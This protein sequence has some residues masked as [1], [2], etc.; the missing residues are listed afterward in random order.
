MV[1]RHRL[2]AN[3]SGV[4]P[5]FLYFIKFQKSYIV[6]RGTIVGTLIVKRSESKSFLVELACSDIL[7]R[8]KEFGTLRF[9]GKSKGSK[10]GLCTL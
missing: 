3:I 9:E 5:Y 6:G 10:A 7:K 4:Y 8:F 1:V 2:S